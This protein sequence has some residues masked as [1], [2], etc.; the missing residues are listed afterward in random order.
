LFWP[1]LTSRPGRSFLAVH[2]CTAGNPA[3]GYAKKYGNRSYGRVG[4]G[5]VTGQLCDDRVRRI[6]G[7]QLFAL[8]LAIDRAASEAIS[9][10][11]AVTAKTLGVT[12]KAFGPA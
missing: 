5:S 1:S 6:P 2:P 8:D 7:L 10:P 9:K 4:L 11:F 12:D 3:K